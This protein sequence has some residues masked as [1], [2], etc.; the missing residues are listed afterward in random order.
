MS[1]FLRFYFALT[2]VPSTIAETVSPKKAD[3]ILGGAS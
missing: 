2:G 3:T 1:S